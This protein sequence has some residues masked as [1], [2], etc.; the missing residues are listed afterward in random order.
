[1]KNTILRKLL[2]I[3]ALVFLSFPQFGCEDQELAVEDANSEKDGSLI[4]PD[5]DIP[6]PPPAAESFGLLP[7]PIWVAVE[8]VYSNKIIQTP[9]AG[10]ENVDAEISNHGICQTSDAS[11]VCD[12]DIPETQLFYSD[13]KLTVG[14]MADSECELIRFRPYYYLASRALDFNPLW[15][16]EGEITDCSLGDSIFTINSQCFSG[17]ALDSGLGA[18]PASTNKVFSTQIQKAAR[19]TIRS[20]F[21]QGRN[22]NRWTANKHG[23]VSPG[24]PAPSS[25]SSGRDGYDGSIP[26]TWQDYQFECLNRFGDVL[27]RITLAITDVHD[28]FGSTGAGGN[29]DGWP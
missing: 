5:A 14:T 29:I 15:R 26:L 8:S 28:P 12:V 27:N 4:E 18:F 7:Y 6:P 3:N 16:R 2:F 19:F 13:L 21:E 1:M 20:S 23:G 11:Y 24:E 10:L 17:S 22:S 9:P 25:L